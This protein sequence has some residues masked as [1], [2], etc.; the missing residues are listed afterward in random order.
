M[1]YSYYLGVTENGQPQQLL[2]FEFQE[3]LYC[4]Y[5]QDQTGRGQ[6]L[7]QKLDSGIGRTNSPVDLGDTSTVSTK[8]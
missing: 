6:G 4:Q 7:R 5:P 3:R 8:Q 2:F 1:G